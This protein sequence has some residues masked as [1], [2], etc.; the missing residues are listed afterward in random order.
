MTQQQQQQ[1]CAL[2]SLRYDAGAYRQDLRQSVSVGQYVMAP[3]SGRQHCQPCLPTDTALSASGVGGAA[4]R[5]GNAAVDIESDLHNLTRRATRAPDC[6]YD[7]TKHWNEEA[8]KLC[9]VAPSDSCPTRAAVDTRL[10][11]PSCTLRGTGWNRFE[12][13]CRDPQENAMLPFDAHVNTSLLIK[14]NHRPH[15]ATPIDPSSA[16]PDPNAKFSSPMMSAACISHPE[17][18]PEVTTWRTC[19]ELRT[20]SDG[21]RPV[22]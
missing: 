6:M 8:T 22:A 10:A 20:L 14:D 7:P 2:S 15:L 9:T 21:C 17:P 13:L 16:L 4:N 19:G 12:W 1:P 3:Y 11:Y 5:C 18:M